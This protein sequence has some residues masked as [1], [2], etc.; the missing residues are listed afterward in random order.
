MNHK[1]KMKNMTPAELSA[2][3]RSVLLL[4]TEGTTEW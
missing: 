4:I 3:A 2:S 1:N